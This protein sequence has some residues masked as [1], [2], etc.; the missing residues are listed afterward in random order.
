MIALK[1][2]KN[3]AY[4]III[5]TF[6]FIFLFM[7]SSCQ[8]TAKNVSTEITMDNGEAG[9]LADN[10]AVDF[11]FY[12]PENFT[13]DK[14]AAMI[15]IY[16]NDSEVL[17]MD[18]NA[19]DSGENFTVLTKPNLS[20]TAFG[21]PDGMYETID[22]YWNNFAVPYR[23]EVFQDV[24]NASSEDLTVAD[25]PAKKYIY[26]FSSMGMKYKIAEVVFFR[27]R[28]VYIL[29][30]TAPE[31]KFDKYANVLDTAAET[32]KFK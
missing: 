20:A 30:Y 31:D 13:L 21:L 25:L 12:Y 8:V 16:I 15:S 2:F 11:Y 17:T 24:V 3:P 29:T 7:I 14:N 6:A 26:A 28:Q 23:E 5:L 32:F 19:P 22:D 1:K 4:I 27:E 9:I 10:N 18:K